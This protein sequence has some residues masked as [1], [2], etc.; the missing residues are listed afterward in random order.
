MSLPGEVMRWAVLI[1]AVAALISGCGGEEKLIIFHAGSLS[2]PMADLVEAF[3]RLHPEVEVQRE[4][5]GSLVAARKVSEL[6]READLV[7]VA[8][9]KVIEAILMPDYADWYV[10]F[11]GNRMVIA[12]TERSRYGDEINSDNWFEILARK[13]VRFGRSDPNMDPCGYRTLMVWQLADIYYKDRLKGRSIY[14][15]LMENCPPSNIRQGSVELLPLLESLDLDYAFEY[16][17][18]A[19]QHRLRYVEL[20]REIDLSDPDLEELYAK[21]QVR[22]TGKKPG[23]YIVIKGS[24]IVYGVTIPKGAPHYDL[25]VDFLKLMLSEEGKRIM[26]ENGQPPIDPPLAVGVRNMPPELRELV[27]GER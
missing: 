9:Y 23:E 5:S 17:S 7:A 11:A 16:L 15:T 25:A 22:I 3:K 18:V 2:K 8:D 1:S 20:P 19:K 27:R 13:D 21:A 6:R 10:K 4:A 12:Y 26:D 24:P 14:E